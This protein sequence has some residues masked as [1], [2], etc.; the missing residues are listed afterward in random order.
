MPDSV[1]EE[2]LGPVRS[3]TG[4]WGS[5]EAPRS[6]RRGPGG[7][8]RGVRCA[9]DAARAGTGWR[10]AAG[11]RPTSR[12]PRCHPG[13]APLRA[14]CPE[15]GAGAEAVPWARSAAS[16]FA[17]ASGGA[18]VS[19]ARGHGRAQADALPGLPAGGQG[20]G[21]EVAADGARRTRE[22]RV[23]RGEAQARPLG[24]AAGAPGGARGRR[25][26]APGW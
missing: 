6:S 19:A 26:T 4:G 16:R 20:K 11:A 14:G 18:D 15:H 9:A 23:A 1:P 25:P 12:R 22:G 3:V 10:R 7:A 5:R 8:R 2:A 17:P 21:I 24:A 13:Y